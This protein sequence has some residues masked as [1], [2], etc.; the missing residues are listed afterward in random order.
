MGGK[1]K[2]YGGFRARGG[3]ERDGVCGGGKCK[4]LEHA[5]GGGHVG[6]GPETE[7][8]N[9]EMILRKTRDA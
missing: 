8:A 3:V 9:V 5:G 4:G 2:E 1:S 7:G 6:G